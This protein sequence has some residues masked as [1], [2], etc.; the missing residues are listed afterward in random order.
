MVTNFSVGKVEIGSGRTVIIA[1]AGVNHLKDINLAERIIKEAAENG[2]DIIK[3][4]TYSADGLVVKNAPRFWD[5]SGEKKHSGTQ[6]DSY[7]PLATPEFDFTKQ[8]KDL[9]DQ[10][11]IEFMSTPFDL[12]AVEV[13]EAL[14]TPAYKVASGDITNFILLDAIGSTEK[15]VF[16]STGASTGA[17]IDCA[18]KRLLRAGTTNLC[19]MHC[20]LSYPTRMNDAHLK[21]IPALQELFPDFHIGLSDHTIGPFIPAL[22]VAL[23]CVAIEKHYTVDKTLPDSA[24]HWLSIDSIELQQMVQNCRVAEAALGHKSKSVSSAEEPARANARRSLV[25]AQDIPAGTEITRE[26]LCAKRPASGISPIYLDDVIGRVIEVTRNE[27]EILE[28]ND[29]QGNAPFKKI[30]PEDFASGSV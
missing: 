11:G 12:E 7:S 15:P 25:A 20:S 21:A 22:S 18:V 3:F 2:A 23:G 17:E 4:Q 16:L 28:P 6:H 13:L 24:D 5:W 8:L 26:M 27:G 9:C 10:Y 1:E 30:Y 29:F 14:G 19:I